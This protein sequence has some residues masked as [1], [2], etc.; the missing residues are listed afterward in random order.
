MFATLVARLDPVL[1]FDLECI[2]L[3]TFFAG[4]EQPDFQIDRKL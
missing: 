1:C 3:Q 4:Q 2:A